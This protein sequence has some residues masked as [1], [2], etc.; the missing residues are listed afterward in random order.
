MVKKLEKQARPKE[1]RKTPWQSVNK[2]DNQ[3]DEVFHLA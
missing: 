2:E 1:A 3:E